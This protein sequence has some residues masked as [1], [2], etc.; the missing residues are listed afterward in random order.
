[1][2][3]SKCSNLCDFTISLELKGLSREPFSTEWGFFEMF[4]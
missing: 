4:L 3:V 1:M 2:W